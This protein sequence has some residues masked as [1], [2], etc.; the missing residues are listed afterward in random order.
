MSKYQ[1]VR[2][3]KGSCQKVGDCGKFRISMVELERYLGPVRPIEKFV[4]AQ[5]HISVK[6]DIDR[7]LSWSEANRLFNGQEGD[8][9]WLWM[10]FANA[11]Y[12]EISNKGEIKYL[13]NLL[14]PIFI[15]AYERRG[16]ATYILGTVFNNFFDDG[17][18]A[19]YQPPN[20]K[21][22][23]L[24]QD[25]HKSA[26]IECREL[27]MMMTRLVKSAEFNVKLIKI[28]SNA[29]KETLLFKMAIESSGILFTEEVEQMLK[30]F[31]K[32][33]HSYEQA[34]KGKFWEEVLPDLVEVDYGTGVSWRGK[35]IDNYRLKDVKNFDIE[36]IKKSLEV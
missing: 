23:R 2:I 29:S 35:E 24:S 11:G 9:Q 31:N 12:K 8:R 17:E 25:W 20:A 22:Y 15:G 27:V 13:I 33:W 1:L 6:D 14:E 32:A 18:A 34:G 28:G 7:G 16:D 10:A 36:R 3:C 5:S 4:A 21:E 19:I 26:G 30:M